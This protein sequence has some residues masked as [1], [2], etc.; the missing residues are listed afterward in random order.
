MSLRLK[1]ATYWK[2]T[3]GRKVV[4]SK[5]WLSDLTKCFFLWKPKIG[6][7]MVLG[8]LIFIFKS[9]DGFTLFFYF[10]VFLDS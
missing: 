2:Y 8:Y 5:D 6:P 7:R 1:G 9:L 4:Q 10:F 3:K